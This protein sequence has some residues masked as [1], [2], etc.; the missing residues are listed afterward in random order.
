MVRKNIKAVKDVIE[1]ESHLIPEIVNNNLDA[2]KTFHELAKGKDC[3]VLVAEV[4]GVWME[5]FREKLV[6]EVAMVE[7]EVFESVEESL[8]RGRRSGKQEFDGINVDGQCRSL[9]GEM[10]GEIR[11]KKLVKN[12]VEKNLG[13]MVVPFGSR[14]VVIEDDREG[15]LDED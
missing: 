7:E 14:W 11:V 15:I 4:A 13:L 2:H 10:P 12:V 1:N 8:R 6:V 5:D 9:L 3:L